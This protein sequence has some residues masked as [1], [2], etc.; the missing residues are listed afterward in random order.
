MPFSASKSASAARAS[1]REEK[2]KNKQEEAL[3][4]ELDAKAK[5]EK[6]RQAMMAAALRYLTKREMKELGIEIITVRVDPN[7]TPR[8]PNYMR[9][10]T[11]S[12]RH[13]VA[14][15][16]RRTRKR[17]SGK[18]KTMR[19]GRMRKGGGMRRRR[20]SSRNKRGGRPEVLITFPINLNIFDNDI[21]TS[22]EPQLVYQFSNILSIYAKKQED[23]SIK[24]YL[25][26]ANF[27][28]SDDEEIKNMLF[29]LMIDKE[30]GF[31]SYG[32]DVTLAMESRYPKGSNV[33]QPVELTKEQAEYLFTKMDKKDILDG[34]IRDASISLGPKFN[35]S[36]MLEEHDT[37]KGA[38]GAAVSELE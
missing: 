12:A 25:K 9:P 5:D 30:T 19:R 7:A 23:G 14:K 16:G 22:E 31:I 17:R 10:T 13:H 35:A 2:H 28:I 27:K 32:L 24:L 4:K 29:K 26:M 15:G 3:Q 21:K 20:H 33:N 18:K 34:F 36:G 37:R 38:A 11:A 6:Y 1:I 8:S